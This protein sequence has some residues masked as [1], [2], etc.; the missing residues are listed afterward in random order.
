MATIR[1][2]NIKL[3]G[4]SGSPYG[5]ESFAS[6]VPVEVGWA[7]LNAFVASFMPHTLCDRRESRLLTRVTAT[8]PPPAT[9]AN[10]DIRVTIYFRDPSTLEVLFFS[11]PAPVAADIETSPAGKRVKQSAVALIVGYISLVAGITYVPLYGTYKEKV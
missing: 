2:G 5:N 7:Q 1:Y 9:G 4:D 3:I 10:T 8:A 6:P 11:Y